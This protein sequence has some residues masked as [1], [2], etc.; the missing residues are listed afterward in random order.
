MIITI[1]ITL[2]VMSHM[3]VVVIIKIIVSIIVIKDG[4]LRALEVQLGAAQRP[5]ADELLEPGEVRDGALG[6]VYCIM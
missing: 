4:D 5:Q 1:T 6:P 2:V 3:L